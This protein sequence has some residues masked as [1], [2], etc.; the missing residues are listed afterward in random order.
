MLTHDLASLVQRDA[1]VFLPLSKAYAMPRATEQEREVRG[2]VMEEALWAASLVPLDIMKTAY[3]G[4]LIHEELAEK[5]SRLAISD[6][7]VGVQLLKA[8]IL[9][10]S[11]NI[12][13]NTKSMVDRVRAA[14]IEED[15]RRLIADGT[16]LADQVY[17]KV[18]EAL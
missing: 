4:L 2:E 14:E 11:M 16:R 6:V 18:E 12:F 9:G 13:I 5:G 17:H 15:A 7:G 10:A 3:Q 1:D 8:A